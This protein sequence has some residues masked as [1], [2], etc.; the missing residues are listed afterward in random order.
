[1]EQ[2]KMFKAIGMLTVL[3]CSSRAVHMDQVIVLYK[4]DVNNVCQ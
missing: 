2:R 4:V 1:M 3:L